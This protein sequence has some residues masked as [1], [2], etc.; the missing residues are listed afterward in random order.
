[1]PPTFLLHRGGLEVE[2]IAKGQ[3]FNQSWLCNEAS[4][5]IQI[6]TVLRTSRL[7]NTRIFGVSHA[8]GDNV[9]V[10]SLSS[11][12]ALCISPT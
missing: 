1:M 5:K 7:L 8:P 2:A 10:S 4:I 6:N 9:A 11:H 12:L 3:P